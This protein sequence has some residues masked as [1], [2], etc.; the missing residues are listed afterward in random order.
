[1][2][3]AGELNKSI[4]PDETVTG[5]TSFHFENLDVQSAFNLFLSEEKLWQEE[6]DG[7][8][9]VSAVYS[10]YNHE[11]QVLTVFAKNVTLK[12]II[13]IISEK[14]GKTIL[15]DELPD[16]KISITVN[17]KEIDSILEMCLHKFSEYETEKNDGWFYIKKNSEQTKSGTKKITQNNGLF[18]CSIEHESLKGVIKKVFEL[19]QKQYSFLSGTESK[20]SNLHIEEKEFN[21]FLTIILENASCEWTE[22]NGVYFIFE[23]GRKPSASNHRTTKIIPLKNISV[24]DFMTLIPQEA[25]QGQ[26]YKADKNSNSVILNATENEYEKFIRLVSSLD[27]PVKLEQ[28]KFNLKNIQAEDAVPLIPEQFIIKEPL[29]LKEQN[30]LILYSLPEQKESLSEFIQ[31]IDAPSYSEEINLKY[32]KTSDLF[33]K[34]PPSVKPEWLKESSY[35]NLIFYTGPQNKK[36]AFLKELSLI[37]RPQPQIKYQLLVVQYTDG[38]GQSN[39]NSFSAKKIE[40]D[41]NFSFNGELSNITSLA[42]NVID[43]MGWQFAASLNEQISR[44]KARIFT[45]TTLTSISGK[46]VKFQNTD[47]YRYLE[48]EYDTANSI[49]TASGITQQ[50]TS[51]LIVSLNGWISGNSMIT[52]DVSATVSKQNSE[53]TSSS[54][55]STSERVINTQV[56]TQSGKSIVISGLIKEDETES[57]SR[58]PF[59]SRIPLLGRLFVHKTVSKEKTEIE[60]YII[61]HLILDE[62]KQ[63]PSPDD[64][65][66]TF[67]G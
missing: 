63:V 52:M 49:T 21:D 3:F 41:K 22:E 29:L 35:P 60:L 4:I 8:V 25:S 67:M 12:N 40:G 42:F 50:I 56:R 14:T 55:P 11:K 23:S 54:L 2:V 18:S 61:P 9:K 26:N 1:M 47:T 5:K 46:E 16:E 17:E 65:Y 44:N 62:T 43:S 32:I 37:D 20:I 57:E 24:S 33:Q 39:K 36:E 19:G 64:L 38:K 66:R 31:Q 51:G 53:S 13:E 15:H 28:V 7:T 30:A 34:L 27:V 59:L 48:Y 45:D 6:K 10:Y 58:V